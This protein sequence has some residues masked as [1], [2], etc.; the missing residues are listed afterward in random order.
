M[1]AGLSFALILAAM[2]LVE[3]TASNFH[4]EYTIGTG[5]S[6]L[7]RYEDITHA[8]GTK[9]EYGRYKGWVWYPKRP[10]KETKLFPTS[11]DFWVWPIAQGTCTRISRV[12]HVF[13]LAFVGDGGNCVTQPAQL[14]NSAPSGF[15]FWFGASAC[16]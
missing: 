5:G 13:L 1:N 15:L 10:K 16:D 14:Q 11:R 7:S 6:G 2:Y 12:A 8:I 4:G 9:D 3:E